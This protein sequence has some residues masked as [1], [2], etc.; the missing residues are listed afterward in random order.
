MKKSGLLLFLLIA[1]TFSLRAQVTVDL[2]LDQDA[3]LPGEAIRATVRITNRSGQTLQLGKDQDWLSFEIESKDGFVVVKSGEAPVVGEFTLET[4]KRAIKQVDLAPYFIFPKVGSYSVTATVLIKDWN[5]EITAKAKTFFIIQGSKLWEQQVGLPIPPGATNQIPE[6]R[7]YTL[8]QANYL[9]T[10]L[11]L[12]VQVSNTAGK[13]YRV[14]PIGPMLSFGQPEPQI[15][16]LSNL[17]VLYQDGPRSFNYTVIDSQG[18]VLVRE[19]YDMAPRPKLKVNAEGDLEVV[20]GVRRITA[21]DV[22]PPKP[23][24]SNAATEKP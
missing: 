12:Y 2:S 19:E 21:N 18:N 10:R 5:Q 14:F 6:L 23:A 3:F 20:G 24:E 13:I 1:A 4:S 17:H 15:D 8:H 16:K 7:K 9:R 11:M 22:P